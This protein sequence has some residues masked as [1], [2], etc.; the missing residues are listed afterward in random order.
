MLVVRVYDLPVDPRPYPRGGH[1]RDARYL[2]QVMP[3]FEE[4]PGPPHPGDLVLFWVNGF[5]THGAIVVDWPEVIHAHPEM[6]VIR[7]RADEGTIGDSAVTL[8][9]R[10][11]ET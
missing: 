5:P 3:F 8:L 10:R 7:G 11:A 4:V 9:R 1:I 6:G 2:E